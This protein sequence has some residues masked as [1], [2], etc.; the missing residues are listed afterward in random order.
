[1][2]LL[3]GAQ[4]PVLHTNPKDNMRN[5]ID[6][7]TKA[8]ARMNAKQKPFKRLSSA[9][10]NIRRNVR[11][12]MDCNKAAERIENGGNKGKKKK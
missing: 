9:E 7:I 3:K 10:R 5:N 1:M 12:S 8:T 11:L 4:G 2:F 6:K